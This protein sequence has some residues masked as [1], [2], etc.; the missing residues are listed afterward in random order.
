M[1][2]FELR[3]ISAAAVPESIAKAEHYRLLNESEQAESICR[4]VLEIEPANQQALVVLVLA[5]T[6]QF[7]Q[8]SST[9]RFEEARDR[10]AELESEYQRSYYGGIAW[11]R[12]ARANL[13]SAMSQGF[14][15]DAFRNAMDRY[16]QALALRLPDD[17]NAI[18]RWNAC[19]RAIQRNNLEPPPDEG[20]L[21]LE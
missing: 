19:V 13:H 18:L 2:E 16:E 20:E 15:Y 8:P 5:L 10:A 14:A 21:P 6:D 11:E 4:D 9:G 12:R 3:T 7:G 1:E 17:D